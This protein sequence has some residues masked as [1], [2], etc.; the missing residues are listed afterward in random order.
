MLARLVM[1]AERHV[2]CRSCIN[3]SS[4]SI[5]FK[6]NPFTVYEPEL[7]RSILFLR[8]A[9]RHE[10]TLPT[11]RNYYMKKDFFVKM[12]CPSVVTETMQEYGKVWL[13][14]IAR[15]SGAQIEISQDGEF[16][17]NTEDRV[18][19]ITGSYECIRRAIEVLVQELLQVCNLIFCF[20]FLFYSPS[21][22]CCQI[23]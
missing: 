12:L 7:A 20:R 22:F 14:Q 4:S 6:S 15:Y 11:P 18:I 13:K 17:P 19:A 2:T 16:F 1:G 9:I 3:S 8:T 5:S 21:F 23:M 10:R